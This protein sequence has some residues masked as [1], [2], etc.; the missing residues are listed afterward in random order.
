MGSHGIYKC[1]GRA[2]RTEDGNDVDIKV[3]KSLRVALATN[4]LWRRAIDVAVTK[5]GVERVAQSANVGR[6]TRLGSHS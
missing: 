5:W 4:N 1:F 2:A 6:T 3:E